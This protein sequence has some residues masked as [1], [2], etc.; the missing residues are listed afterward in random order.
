M[1][2]EIH[3]LPSIQ[4]LS[5]LLKQEKV[6]FEVFENYPKQTYR[7]RAKILTANGVENIIVPTMHQSGHKIFTKDVCI[8][9]SQNWQ[10]Q[11]LGALQA[12]Y[13]KSAF[14]EYFMPLFLEVY[15]KKSKFL[16]DLNIDLLLTIFKIV[17]KRVDFSYSDTFESDGANWFNR[18]T[19]KKEL[20]VKH[21]FNYR[22]CFGTE[23]VGDLSVID[24]LMNEGRDAVSILSRIEFEHF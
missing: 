15:Q 1:H 24:L 12:A 7:N 5:L 22:Q 10:K 23:F 11:H 3:Y 16:L 8:D 4:Y 9:Y 17:G 21:K 18:I 14:Y 20:I 19:P 13:G 2:I 6:C